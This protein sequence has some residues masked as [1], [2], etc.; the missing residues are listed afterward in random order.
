[1]SNVIF[2]TIYYIRHT[3][4]TE[5]CQNVP[6][7][8][9]VQNNGFR[10]AGRTFVSKAQIFQGHYDQKRRTWNMYIFRRCPLTE[11]VGYGDDLEPLKYPK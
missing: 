3:K 6:G 9:Y 2:F 8:L 11:E 1:M 7:S 5:F 10:V 4:K